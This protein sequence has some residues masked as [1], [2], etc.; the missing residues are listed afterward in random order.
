MR[1]QTNLRHGTILH[2]REL[3]TSHRH[4]Y[5]DSGQCRLSFPPRRPAVRRAQQR[6]RRTWSAGRHG[7]V[8]RYRLARLERLTTCLRHRSCGRRRWAE[9]RIRPTMLI[10][11]GRKVS[12][13]GRERSAVVLPYLRREALGPSEGCPY[14]QTVRCWSGTRQS[15]V[16]NFG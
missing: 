7:S 3:C 10:L 1:A 9:R 4:R 15:E 8:V 6:H 13:D 11:L 16:F 2:N 14:L 12:V 5:C